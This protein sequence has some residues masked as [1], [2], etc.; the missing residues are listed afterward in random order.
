MS[1]SYRITRLLAAALLLTLGSAR[2]L[3]G[4]GAAAAAVTHVAGY[5]GEVDGFRSWY[6]SY[7]MG[8]IGTAWCI[9]HGIRAPDPAYRYV[10]DAVGDHSP[11]T[12]T[13]L[14]WAFGR[15]GV[16]PDRVT[17]AALMLVAHDLMG[18]RYPSGPLDVDQ[19]F[20][21]GMQ[22]FGTDAA[23]VVE[24]ARLIKD[25]AVAHGHLLP[26]YALTID[27]PAPTA[28]AEGRATV[29][30]VDAHGSPVA[31]VEVRASAG[32]AT[33]TGSTAAITDS[34][35]VAGF[36]FVGAL[37]P[38]RIDVVTDAPDLV[39]QAFASSTTP[40]QRVARAATVRLTAMAEGFGFG[41]GTL[42]ITKRGD[43]APFLPVTGA[44]FEVYAVLGDAEVPNLVGDVALV[45]GPDGIAGPVELAEG[46]YVVREATPPPGYAP[47]GPWTIDVP[48]GGTIV[49][50][51]D[52]LA[53]RSSLS[54]RKVD[55]VSGVAVAGAVLAVHRDDDLD[56][57]YETAITEITTTLEPVAVADLLPGR[58]R[59]LEVAAPP[60]YQLATAPVDVVLD[61]AA[62]VDVAVADRPVPTTTTTSTST[63]TTS[64]TTMPDTTTTTAAVVVTTAGAAPAPLPPAA[65][66]P[67]SLPH[68]GTDRV[69]LTATGTGAILLG[70]SLRPRSRRYLTP[71]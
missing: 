20:F 44:R 4:P 13:A 49:L 5:Q 28:G 21:P 16:A 31:G 39:L 63:T 19:L 55:A 6:G 1:P 56:G 34:D 33:L 10:P 53:A 70:A 14:A 71:V 62:S 24:R 2:L 51:V 12:R 48:P 30:L 47:A 35:G 45:I 23:A 27:A 36:G 60:G 8:A 26:P 22:G 29:R 66:V 50:E 43:A 42:T 67:R 7:G 9:D 41:R 25:D 17:S 54:L 61:A 38:Y 58:Y 46:R 40:A 37:G 69:G 57:T 59:V 18:A 65:P 3:P 64:T 52:D 32:A 11:P 68:T 15:Y